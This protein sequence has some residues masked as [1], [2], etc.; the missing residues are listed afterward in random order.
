MDLHLL[1]FI[2]YLLSLTV[3]TVHYPPVRRWL[4]S[5]DNY[6]EP[7]AISWEGSTDI[8]VHKVTHQEPEPNEVV[9]TAP[10]KGTIRLPQQGRPSAH[11]ILDSRL[12]TGHPLK[13][14]NR[15]LGKK[16]PVV[17]AIQTVEVALCVHTNLDEL[18]ETL[19][20]C[21]LTILAVS[22][23]AA[24]FNHQI[25]RAY[26]LEISRLIN[27]RAEQQASA[28]CKWSQTPTKKQG[29]EAHNVPDSLAHPIKPA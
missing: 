23:I 21:C 18:S 5:Q 4:T 7:P 11:P 12:W 13:D 8:Q 15:P 24:L 6:N 1:G 9:D 26:H 3:L 28:L 2:A 22:L 20:I 14:Q 10:A 16:K 19:T 27:S 25:R 17:T 29:P